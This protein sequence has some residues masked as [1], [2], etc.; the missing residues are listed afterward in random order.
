MSP[1]LSKLPKLSPQKD[2]Q[3][4]LRL[5]SSSIDRLAPYLVFGKNRFGD[6]IRFLDISTTELITTDK[7]IP[8]ELLEAK[9]TI[10]ASQG[11]VATLNDETMDSSTQPHEHEEQFEPEEAPEEQLEP[12]EAPEEQLVPAEAAEDALI[13]PAGPITRSRSK[14][15][16]QTISGLLKELDKNQEDMAQTTMTLL[17][18]QG[19]R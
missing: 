7:K 19:A 2:S 12:E 14:R 13:V 16:N 6:D 11:W 17:T 1:F 18:A 3:I 10:G 9:S 8:S 5:F 4:S 15:F